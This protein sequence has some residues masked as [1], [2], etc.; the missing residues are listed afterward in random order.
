MRVTAVTQAADVLLGAIRPRG[1]DIRGLWVCAANDGDATRTGSR[2][3]HLRAA[4][5]CAVSKKSHFQLAGLS[6]LLTM[7][8]STW[9]ICEK[10]ILCEE[11]KAVFFVFFVIVVFFLEKICIILRR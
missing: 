7:L 11:R 9:P 8:G 1:D 10:E 5:C 4:G 2:K 3:R 6:S